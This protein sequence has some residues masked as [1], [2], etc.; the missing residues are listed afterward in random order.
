LKA[1]VESRSEWCISRQ[2][3]WGVPIP[4]F[5]NSKTKELL[6]NYETLEHFENM[7]KE[8]G[9]DCWWAYDA[10]Q[11]LP[12][13]YRFEN[14]GIIFEKTFDTL[15][16]WFDSGTSWA[17]V[18]NSRNVDVPCDLV[19]EGSDQHRGWFQSLLLTS[20]AINEKAPY[21]KIL[22]HGFVVDEKMQKMSKSLG[23]IVSPKDII[24]G[25]KG[26]FEAN[27]SDILRFWVASANTTNE[28]SVGPQVIA[29]NALSVRKIRNTF[30]YLLGSLSDF[31]P[32]HSRSLFDP[33]NYETNF[34]PLEK[35]IL[36]YF[37]SYMDMAESSFENF[38]I[39]RIVK[40]TEVLVTSVLSQMYFEA[41]KASLYSDDPQGHDRYMMQAV[42]FEA[43]QCLLKSVGPI[44]PHTTQDVYNHIQHI[45]LKKAIH[46]EV[47]ELSDIQKE[48]FFNSPWPNSEY[49]SIWKNDKLLKEWDHVLVFREKLNSILE[50]ARVEEKFFQGNFSEVCVNLIP[51][52][53]ESD[54]L[55]TLLSHLESLSQF[56]QLHSFLC[57]S[58]ASL[59]SNIPSDELPVLIRDLE[60]ESGIAFNV[61]IYHPQGQ[62]KC[63][64]CRR[65]AKYCSEIDTS[66]GIKS[67]CLNCINVL[68]KS[69]FVE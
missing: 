46:Q 64:R 15:D 45:P 39:Y 41:I 2:R 36:A 53:S 19:I 24:Q 8:H 28:V 67:L 13:K 30:R 69:G 32:V 48:T 54:E 23:N 66:Q 12:P 4:A 3:H 5:R 52:K 11:L 35:F 38:E 26:K 34:K 33:I 44:L 42:L 1:T 21:K 14:S 18:L 57:V 20:T 29:R 10:E 56:N 27:G 58:E 65:Y 7:V 22:S 59:N 25:S 9:V 55:E 49:R 37:A 50:N 60:V 62:T 31:E 40:S 6:M 43:F 68:E 17:G 16:V 63:N 51:K 47:S 61:Q